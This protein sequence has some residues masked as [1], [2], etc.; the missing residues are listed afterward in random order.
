M[1]A[2]QTSAADNRRMQRRTARPGTTVECRKGTL[3]L[4]PD[5][6]VEMLDFSADGVLM[7]IR[8]AV[9]IGDEIEL[10]ITAPGFS[11]PTVLEATAVRCIPQAGGGYCM[12]AQFR[13]PLSYADMYHLM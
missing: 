4:G 7:S 1:S 12:A 5:I 8:E 11:R 2:T 10:S 9:A 3:G 13:S 6:A